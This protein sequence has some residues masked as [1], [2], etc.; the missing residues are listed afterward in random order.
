LCA[1]GSLRDN[2]FRGDFVLFV[3]SL[4]CTL[5]DD[6]LNH[7]LFSIFFLRFFSCDALDHF[8]RTG[9]NAAMSKFSSR[10][11]SPFPVRELPAANYGI[12]F[13]DGMV[14]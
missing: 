2:S 7:K 4:H 1:R 14:E 10:R 13:T 6:P 5:G 9:K 8:V 3:S 11:F 12:V